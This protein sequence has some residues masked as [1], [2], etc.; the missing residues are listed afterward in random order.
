M[1]FH[2]SHARD[3]S[4][5]RLSVLNRWLIAGSVALTGLLTEVTAHA[6]PSKAKTGSAGKSS[7]KHPR[8]RSAAK[9][10]PS[11]PKPLSPPAQPPQASPEPAP[12]SAPAPDASSPRSDA[13]AQEAAPEQRAPEQSAPEQRAPEQSVAPERSPEPAPEASAPVVS[14]GS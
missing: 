12:E 4:L 9:P 2:T 7:G 13:P 8:H 11:K 5:R 1:R 10:R 14:G 6:F 3:S